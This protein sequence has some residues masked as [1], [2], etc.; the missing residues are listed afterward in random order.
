MKLPKLTVPR[1]FLFAAAAAF[2]PSAKAANLDLVVEDG[3]GGTGIM[4][5][6]GLNTFGSAGVS[7]I[8]TN[9]YTEGGAGSG[10]GAGLGGVFFVNQG[11]SLT[12]TNVSFKS[13]TVKGGEAGSN[14]PRSVGG[15][16][17]ALFE[18]RASVGEIPAFNIKPNLTV[19]GS[20][21]VFSSVTLSASNKLIKTGSLA[22]FGDGYAQ[23]QISAVS[24]TSVSF[25]NQ[26]VVAS[27]DVTNAYG[28]VS[29]GSSLPARWSLRSSSTPTT[30]SWGS[31]STRPPPARV[32]SIS[33]PSTSPS[34][35]PPSS[36]PAPA[37]I[38][39]S[40]TPLAW[41]SSW[42]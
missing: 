5:Y 21:Y 29:S 27:S 19:S 36:R 38:R 18:K 13:N 20:N 9:Y 31:R 17:I 40:S 7:T 42:A 30:R 35:P 22:D 39:S 12:L 14:P 33:T 11:A 28:A 8:Y 25:Q 26:V 24:G 4:L 2:L 16:E 34:S 3:N 15:F 32:E 23:N 1:A 37:P 41:G 6:E 10:G